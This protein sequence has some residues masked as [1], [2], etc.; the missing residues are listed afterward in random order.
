MRRPILA[1]EECDRGDRNDRA[2]QASRATLVAE[3]VGIMRLNAHAQAP[4][5]EAMDSAEPAAW[6]WVSVGHR[7]CGVVDVPARKVIKGDRMG[8]ASPI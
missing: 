2:W 3:W 5:P 8:S 6:A 7:R 1:R 4:P